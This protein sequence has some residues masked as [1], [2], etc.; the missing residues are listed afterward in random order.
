MAQDPSDARERLDVVHQRRA[1]V[2]AALY[3][4][5]RAGPH[6]RAPS[7]ERLEERGLL[8]AHVASLS[9]DDLDVETPLAAEDSRAEDA[10]LSRVEHCAA[11][12][13]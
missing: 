10:R 12:R 13:R 2:E 8:A 11:D 5:G 6:F 1:A 4:I 9:V 7:F 3:R